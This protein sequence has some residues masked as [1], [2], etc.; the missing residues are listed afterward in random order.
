MRENAHMS[1]KTPEHPVDEP[2]PRRPADEPNPPY[3]PLELDTPKVDSIKKNAEEGDM[4]KR[5]DD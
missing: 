4:E 5:H 2:T 3:P 1:K